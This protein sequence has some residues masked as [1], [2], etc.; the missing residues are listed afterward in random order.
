MAETQQR[1]AD[2]DQLVDSLSSRERELFQRIFH[3]STTIGALKPPASM[4]GWIES[5]FGSIEAVLKQRIVKVTNLVTL[6]GSLFNE[7]RSMRP[8][9]AKDASDLNEA[10][11]RNLGDPFCNPLEGTP[12]DVFGRIEGRHCITASN[13][14][15]YDGFH[16]IVIFEE[17]HPLVFSPEGV[18]DY[19]DTGIAW[20]EQAHRKDERAKY[21]F[22]MWNC[23]W[24][25]GA[26]IIHG[27]AQVT[28]TR[29]MHYPKVEHLRRAA[30]SYA[31]TYGSNY[32]DDL[33]QV[34]TALDLALERGTT[35]LLAYLTPI[36]EKEVL[37][38]SQRV[39]NDL[40]DCVYQVLS[41]FT[42]MLGVRSFNLAIYMPPI[43]T[44]EEDWHGFPVMVRIVDR[45]D[46]MNKTSDMGGMELYAGSVIA[47]DPFL[48]ASVLRDSLH[49]AP[50]LH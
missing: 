3:V 15:K 43:A 13:I 27:H 24:K 50:L 16:G 44:V 46:P 5:H 29:D 22:F 40:K 25:S 45:G 31:A 33:Y 20:A 11:M 2:L 42:Q 7:L 37:L 4:Y 32:F 10:I 14:A 49:Y 36:K 47:T 9:E 12:E 38:I 1:I 21:F 39:D 8:M 19:I 26:S 23:L 28:L 48:V 6:E 34:H 18:R 17:H 35:R 30:L 41:C